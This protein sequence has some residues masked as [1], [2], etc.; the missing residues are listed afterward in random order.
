[1]LETVFMSIFAVLFSGLV[2][3]R[4][5]Y[6]LK[7]GV[8]RRGIYSRDEGVVLIVLRS[9]LGVPLLAAV[10]FYFLDPLSPGWARIDLPVGLRFSG[11][12]LGSASLILLA[13]AHRALGRNFS[14]TLIF[15]RDH[16]LVTEGPYRYI[17]HPIYAAYLLLFTAGFLVTTH[18]GIGVFGV[19]I[20]GLLMTFR[21]RREEELLE[22]HFG[23]EYLAYS[24][25]TPRFIP[26]LSVF[27]RRRD[28]ESAD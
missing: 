21:L 4:S 11:V 24:G 20:I 10:V 16:R 23:E 2:V 13:R 7:A 28:I 6:K 27:V 9:V 19:S 8:F 12:F 25:K 26:R 1:M 15:Q 3:L 5:I 22:E 18:W 17:R 14:P